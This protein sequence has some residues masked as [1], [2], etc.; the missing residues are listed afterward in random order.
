LVLL[1]ERKGRYIAKRLGLRYVGLLG[2]LVEAKHKQLLPAVKPIVDDLIRS[3]GFWI[4][5]E[6]YAQV[7]RSVKEQ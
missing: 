3:A 5:E 4:D 2:V 6:L 7:L 1:D